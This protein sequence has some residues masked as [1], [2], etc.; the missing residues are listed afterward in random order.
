M[1]GGNPSFMKDIVV[2][3]ELPYNL[4]TSKDLIS[5]QAKISSFGRENIRLIGQ[6]YDKSFLKMSQTL[7]IFIA[8]KRER[9]FKCSCRL[10][11]KYK[12]NVE[13]I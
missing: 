9:Q 7:S 8:K 4:R 11:K 2:E 10:C 1:N 13:F 3:R 6:K 5:K 12:S